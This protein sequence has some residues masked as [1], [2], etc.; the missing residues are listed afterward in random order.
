LLGLLACNEAT[1]RLYCICSEEI[2]EFDCS[3]DTCTR[4]SYVSNYEYPAIACDTLH[5]RLYILVQEDNYVGSLVR[6]D[7]ND[8][9]VAGAPY[10]WPPSA[11]GAAYLWETGNHFDTVPDAWMMGDAAQQFVGGRVSTAGDLDGDGR[12]EF[13]VLNKSCNP[14][15]HVWVCRYT[16][17]G[18]QE[19]KVLRARNEVALGKV[20]NPCHD[21]VRFSCT[22]SMGQNSTLRICD[23]MGR[24]VRTLTLDRGK[25]TAASPAATW[26]LRDN[27]GR[28]VCQGI[29]IVEL[30]Q[31]SGSATGH[32]SAKVIVERQ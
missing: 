3:G 18:I 8:D 11:T 28:R 31:L 26:D 5:N 15:Q 19:D 24:A 30:E 13:L 4:S 25:S 23:V 20:P 2:A 16:G 21:R 29:H 9:L 22:P 17:S 7:G 1:D 10:S 32:C 27:A 12:F 14:R 6:F